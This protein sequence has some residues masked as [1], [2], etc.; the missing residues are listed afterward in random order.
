VSTRLRLSLALL[1]ALLGSRSAAAQEQSY[2]HIVR[3]G[4]TL[5]SIAQAY[6]GNPK[7]QAV[8]RAENGLAEHVEPPGEG[9]R[10]L[11]PA[12]GYHRVVA[13]E[14]WRT[15]AERYYGQP[16]R[17]VALI[18]ANGEKPN[19]APEEGAQLLLPYPLR[20][21][22]E[23]NESLGS[24]AERYYGSRDDQRLLRTFNGGRSKVARGE[25]VLVPLFDL[26]LSRAGMERIGQATTHS[27]CSESGDTKRV[28]A[29]VAEAIPQ[30]R[31]HVLA[32]RFV[33][34]AALGNQLLGRGKLTGNQEISIQR[35][36]ATA[37]VALSREDLAVAA[38]ARALEKQPD[39][40]L[41]SVRTSPRVLHALQAAK[42]QRRR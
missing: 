2:V 36:L 25:I 39:L 24:I 22:A 10:L 18:K 38:F 20:H 23:T 3:S 7:R 41:D 17:A 42:S 9:V 11:I 19:G 31:A 26:V 13:G 27:E 29:E 14:T 5:A 33:E 30:V 6:Y 37:Y 8:L 21:V 15:I 1:L 4:E 32:G 28:Q 34:A 35:E 40:E 16:N 12:V